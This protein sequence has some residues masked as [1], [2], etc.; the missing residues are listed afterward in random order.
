MRQKNVRKEVILKN[1]INI[2]PLSKSTVICSE[3]KKKKNI[4][5]HKGKM[6]I[7]AA[8]VFENLIIIMS[9]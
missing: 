3:L 6:V 7:F 2:M 9:L 1:I 5:V 4:M 8:K